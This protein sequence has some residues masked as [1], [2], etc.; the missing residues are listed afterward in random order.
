MGG[1]A[2]EYCI[3]VE[4]NRKDMYMYIVA[5]IYERQNPIEHWSKRVIFTSG[6]GD[7]ISL[8]ETQV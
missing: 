3:L 8:E 4:W 5:T 6:Q 7:F 1:P 2:R